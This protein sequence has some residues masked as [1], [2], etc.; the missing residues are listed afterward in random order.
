VLPAVVG[1]LLVSLGL[2]GLFCEL[3]MPGGTPASRAS[4]YRAL[5]PSARLLEAAIEPNPQPTLAVWT[6]SALMVPQVELTTYDAGRPRP[7]AGASSSARAPSSFLARKAALSRKL[8]DLISRL[9]GIEASAARPA[10]T[11][12]PGDQALL[13]ATRVAIARVAGFESN[14]AQVQ[15]QASL[16]VLESRASSYG[17]ARLLADVLLARAAYYAGFIEAQFEHLAALAAKASDAP[18]GH[19]MG[20]L[21]SSLDSEVADAT[22]ATSGLGDA[23][24]AP[25]ASGAPPFSSE[26]VAARNELLSARAALEAAR[27]DVVYLIGYLNR[28]APKP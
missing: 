7:E 6:R 9:E 27:R 26:L 4:I 28:S 18:G 14:L 23:L 1:V 24:L 10:W 3:T 17:L 15:T 8:S 11:S 13:I 19:G 2:L 12:L 22:S 25:L 5:P 21:V 20:P 16:S